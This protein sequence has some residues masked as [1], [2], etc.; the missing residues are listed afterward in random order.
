MSLTPLSCA[1]WM[2]GQMPA[3]AGFPSRWGV[4][5]RRLDCRSTHRLGSLVPVYACALR[6]RPDGRAVGAC[7]H[8][9]PWTLVSLARGAWVCVRVCGW[10]CFVVRAGCSLRFV[11]ARVCGVHVAPGIFPGLKLARGPVCVNAWAAGEPVPHPAFSSRDCGRRRL[12]QYDFAPE[13]EERKRRGG[14]EARFGA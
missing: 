8:G 13:A 3:S 12:R 9:Y 5:G 2:S 14:Q 11:V 10:A 6:S 7:V 1:G 4:F